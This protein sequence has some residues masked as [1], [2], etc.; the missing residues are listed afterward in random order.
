MKSKLL[1]ILFFISS[2][3]YAQY[4]GK[5]FYIS[6]NYTYTATS[7]LYLQPN[8]SDAIIRET[9]D[10]IDGLYSYSGAFGYKAFEDIEFNISIE[11]LEKTVNNRNTTL[12]A[13]RVEKKDGY[14]VIPIELS[15]FYTL[16]FS[17]ERFKFF[18][19]GGGGFYI[20][21]HIRKL[22]DVTASTQSRKVGFGILV[23]VGMDYLINNYFV[24]RGQMRFRN[25]VFEMKNK[26]SSTTV[27]Y[28]GSTYY[29]A[30]DTFDSK[31]DIDG[32]SFVIGLLF[33]F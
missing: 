32:V 1:L 16:P 26:Y 11:Y 31:V 28:G 21:D 2:L 27:N 20:G 12:G 29:L 23:D 15:L 22:G 13:T 17:L 14:R 19:G 3:Y 6:A 9:H 5:K 25:P 24:L 10:N 7:K 30:T 8:S 4:N 33:Q 18:M